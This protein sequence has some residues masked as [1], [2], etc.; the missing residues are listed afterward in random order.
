M[1]TSTDAAQSTY[2]FN[3]DNV[4]HLAYAVIMIAILSI[5]FLGNALTVIILRR[6]EHASKSLTP[7]MLNL[8]IGSLIIII[9]GYPV[10]IS[11][12]LSGGQIRKENATCIWS[13][14]VNGTVGISG[15]VT[16]TEM[17]VVINYSLQRLNPNFRF[18]KKTLG[19]LIAGTWIYGIVSMLPPLFGWN[20]FAP[21]AAQISCGPDWTDR[22]AS[23]MS[24]SL[25]LVIL[26]FFLP[27]LVMCSAYYKIYRILRSRELFIGECCHF[28]V[29]QKLYM[30]KLV[31]MT[32]IAI[33]VFMLSWAP[34]CLVSIVAVF[35]GSHVFTNGEAEIPALMA[36]ASVIYN[37]IVYIVTN[38]SFRSSFW[39]VI[40]CER[41]N[42]VLHI[43]RNVAVVKG[44][45]RRFH[46]RRMAIF[47]KPLNE[48]NVYTGA[49]IVGLSH[50]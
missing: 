24:Y 47:F 46:S 17:S 1:S 18:S 49:Y 39:K 6:H 9:L 50:R 31:R 8:S 2:T 43:N 25:I 36:K 21:G 3:W 4:W 10:I 13:A 28:Q 37:P 38:G 32:V 20:R 11:L 14:F 34:Y 22:T 35:K 44:S 42:F 30:T 40:S 29:R 33:A 23:G 15:I 48:V 12:L 41:R 16:L 27:L 19:F 5:G 7:L 26:G 45:S